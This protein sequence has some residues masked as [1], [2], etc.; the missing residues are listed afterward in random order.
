MLLISIRSHRVVGNIHA[1]AIHIELRARSG[2]LHIVFTVVLRHPRPLDKPA[3]VGISRMV[4]AETL[5]AVIVKVEPEQFL[6]LALRMETPVRVK[7]HSPDRKHVGRPPEHISPAV[8]VD[9]QIRILQIEQYSRLG[10]PFPGFRVVGIHH[11]HRS[12]RVAAHIQHRIAVIVRRRSVTSLR[13]P[14]LRLDEIPILQISRMPITIGT[15]HEHIIFPTEFHDSRV[16]ARTVGNIFLRVINHIC[17]IHIKRIAISI[18]TQV[19]G[20]SRCQK[21][22]GSHPCQ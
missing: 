19:L 10:L 11:A 14:I 9:K 12:R 18:H 17:V 16:C 5:P 21:Y 13:I 7:F 20:K 15:R 6:T 2:I 3:K 8:I 4:L 1:V 22:C